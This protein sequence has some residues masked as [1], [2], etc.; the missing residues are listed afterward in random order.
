AFKFTKKFYFFEKTL[1][2]SSYLLFVVSFSLVLSKVFEMTDVK[3]SIWFYIFIF[4]MI[5]DYLV[6]KYINRE[7]AVFLFNLAVAVLLVT[8]GII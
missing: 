6:I 4:F 2:Y 3:T 5:A 1:N 8:W 7:W